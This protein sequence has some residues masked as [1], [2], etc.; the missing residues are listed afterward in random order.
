MILMPLLLAGVAALGVWA[1]MAWSKKRRQAWEAVAA[2][3]GAVF[4]DGT[5]WKGSQIEGRLAHVHLRLESYTKQVGKSSQRF[6]RLK[7]T[8]GRIDPGLSLKKEGL[9]TSLTKMFTGADLQM[10]D[11]SFDATVLVDGP[12][13]LTVATMDAETRQLVV[14]H[15]R[16]GGTVQKLE[17]TLDKSGTWTDAAAIIQRFEQMR[18]LVAKLEVHPND[19]P[20]RLAVNAQSEAQVSV[21]RRNLQLLLRHYGP[22][23]AAKE[24]ATA[25][26]ADGA[27]WI[28]V[29]SAYFLGGDAGLK[30]LAE[31]AGDGRMADDL[32]ARAIHG[33]DRHGHRAS[34]ELL[35]DI[36]EAGPLLAEA[37]ARWA[38]S[39]ADVPQ[40]TLLQLLA[41]PETTVS[42][43][44]ARALGKHGDVGAVEALL[45]LT[46]G[47]FAD[48]DQKTVAR[49]A[50]RQIQS[51]A[52]DVGAGR[53]SLADAPC[54]GGLSL[55][56]EQADV[57][58]PEDA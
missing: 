7:L 39:G 5:F 45:P 28:R 22:H 21:R 31:A 29:E 19:I 11:A 47:I 16:A 10:K 36:A 8:T 3:F 40:A 57:A 6:T 58:S 13:A 37:V 50:I 35:G 41:R 12:E 1:V 48:G 17:V 2:H 46:R 24:A 4:T 27:G 52:G 26:L 32:R 44:A 56:E 20:R 34:R 23:P 53:I 30:V 9:G 55:M 38:F 33:L 42:T 49:S 15:V 54:E 43:E 25:G 18:V 14:D 51:R